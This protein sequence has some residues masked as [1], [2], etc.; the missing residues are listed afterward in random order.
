MKFLF[1]FLVLI[2]SVV[3]TIILIV[4]LFS[5]NNSQSKPTNVVSSYDLQEAG[6]VDSVIKVT[7]SG[8]T[9]AEENYKSIRYTI[10]KN[11]RTV[12]SLKG[13]KGTVDKSQ[14]LTNSP[15]SY[16][17]LLAALTTVQFSKK[18]DS[19]AQLDTTCASGN[20]YVF[21]LASGGKQ[22]F[23]TWTS[24]C[25]LRGGTFAGDAGS[26]NQLIKAQ[27]PN[28]SDIPVAYSF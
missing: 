21:E 8:P 27:F 18:R 15:E 23:S 5:S 2:I 13:Y 19:G 25:S 11:T 26:V 24:S 6:A 1:G 12:E 10:S 3:V 14:V 7:V 4:S 28:L 22:Q 16:K 20:K 17:A 9:V